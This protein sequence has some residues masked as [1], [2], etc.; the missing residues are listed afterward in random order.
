MTTPKNVLPNWA[1]AQASPW[2]SVN[3][4]L[5]DIDQLMNISVLD[6]SLTAPP[7]GEGDG[8]AYIVAAGS[9]G[10]WSGQD[11]KLAYFING[12]YFYKSLPMGT[13]IYNTA[14]SKHYAWNGSAY[15]EFAGGGGSGSIAIDEEGVEI[16][17]SASRFNFIGGGV[18]VADAGFGVADITVTASSAGSGGGAGAWAFKENISTTGVA[19]ILI[20]VA[21]A[22]E[23]MLVGKN[24]ETSSGGFAHLRFSPDGGTTIRNGAAE[25]HLMFV[26]AAND[27]IQNIN[28]VPLVRSTG[29]QAFLVKLNAVSLSKST[30]FNSHIGDSTGTIIKTGWN[31]TEEAHDTIVLEASAGTFSAMDVDVYVRSQ[32]LAETGHA[33][34]DSLPDDYKR[35]GVDGKK[36]ADPAFLHGY[37]VTVLDAGVTEFEVKTGPKSWAK[38]AYQ[39]N[40]VL[41]IWA[42]FG[43]TPTTPISG[44]QVSQVFPS[45]LSGAGG[46]YTGP[47]SGG[48]CQAKVADNG[49][50]QVFYE[51]TGTHYTTIEWVEP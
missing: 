35:L 12:G 49:E 5:Y 14:D 51:V 22:D 11:H 8:D 26:Y 45:E 39:Q 19:Q 15:S 20:D 6:V 10:D 42:A 40:P 33:A 37:F 29:A 46:Y 3:Q 44:S 21:G 24:V 41:N 23:V 27:D 30:M 32:L 1:A 9:S 18:S 13:I 28:S 50:L 17:A 38:S 7:G 47:N 4:A 34:T 25:Y 43:A 2:A 31:E 16:L 36:Y 48:Y